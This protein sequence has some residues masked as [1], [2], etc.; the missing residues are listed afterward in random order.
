M[1]ERGA[2]SE[3]RSIAARQALAFAWA[4]GIGEGADRAGEARSGKGQTAARAP[5]DSRSM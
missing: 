2:G 1:C 3:Q 5:A 4:A